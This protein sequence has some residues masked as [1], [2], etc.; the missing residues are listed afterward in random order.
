VRI[1]WVHPSWRDLVIDRLAADPAARREFL[2]ACGV[3]GALLALSVGGGYSGERALPL[4]QSDADWDALGAGLH[5]LL[6]D[7][8]DPGLV[9]LLG[10]LGAAASAP[11]PAARRREL[12]ALTLA[13]L[14]QVRDRWDAG[15]LP[16]ALP[17]LEAWF[18]ATTR[19]HEPPRPPDVAATWIEL[20]PDGDEPSAEW[21]ALARL[22]RD[23]A[24]ETLERLPRHELPERPPDP[25]PEETVLIEVLPVPD[26]IAV[27]ES[28]RLIERVLLDL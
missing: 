23:H 24:P 10:A 28:E 9:R 5:L 27:D 18:D 7:A 21:L 19:L 16:L 20:L 25:E 22:L 2:A 26:D 12:D 11:L 8:D 17:P 4:L 1:A 6:R 15:H 3:E 14:E 13:A